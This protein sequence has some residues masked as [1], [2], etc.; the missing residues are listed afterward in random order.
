M[1]RI[2]DYAR[3]RGIGRIYGVVLRENTAML[4]LCERLGFSRAEVADEPGIVR[5]MLEL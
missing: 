5:V 4:S 2:I 3:G 1:R